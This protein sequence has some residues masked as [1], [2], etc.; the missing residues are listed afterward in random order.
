MDDRI[1]LA[2][3][4]AMLVA[5][6]DHRRITFT[7]IERVIGIN[8][9]IV[10]LGRHVRAIYR[11]IGAAELRSTLDRHRPQA[12]SVFQVPHFGTIGETGKG[13]PDS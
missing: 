12:E 2:I 11:R 10:Q 3:R 8:R 7:Q 5:G 6:T 4:A 1:I 13:V 9:E